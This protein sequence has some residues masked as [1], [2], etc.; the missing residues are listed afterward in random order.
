ME[1]RKYKL[2]W[3]LLLLSVAC[4]VISLYLDSK[5]IEDTTWFARSGSLVVLA[6]AIVEFRLSKFFYDDVFHSLKKT[7]K[8]QSGLSAVSDNKLIQKLIESNLIEKPAMPKSRKILR[9]FSHGLII[10]G[11]IIWG[12]G[13]I[14]N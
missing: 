14:Y 1:N 7:A 8:K 6:S 13:D 2:E 11:T 5:S 12:Y 9:N 10:V 3:L 4:A